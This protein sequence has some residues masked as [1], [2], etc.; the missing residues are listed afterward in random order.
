MRRA[1]KQLLEEDGNIDVV[2]EADDFGSALEQTRVRRPRVV[3]LDV[4]MPGASGL[5]SI[6]ELRSNAPDAGLVLVT[7]ENNPTFANRALECG[8]LGL[9]LKDA[10]EIE[11]SEAVRRAARGEEYRSPRVKHG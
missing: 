2:G 11:L 5:A 8:G 4:R 6:R 7:M 1:L 9:V 3:V 10:A